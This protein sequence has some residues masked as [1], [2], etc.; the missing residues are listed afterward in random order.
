MQNTTPEE[1][2]LSQDRPHL[3]TRLYNLGGVLDNN[4][5]NDIATQLPLLPH[6]PFLAPRTGIC[7]FLCNCTLAG[8]TCWS[9]TLTKTVREEKRSCLERIMTPLG[10]FVRSYWVETLIDRPATMRL[11]CRNKQ[12]SK[13]TENRAAPTVLEKV[14]RVLVA[15]RKI[16]REKIKHRTDQIETGCLVLKQPCF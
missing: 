11:K 7:S 4:W 3:P 15:E 9:S 10:R 1:V 12:W 13:S 14:R 6:L 2:L 5:Q 16:H 8:N